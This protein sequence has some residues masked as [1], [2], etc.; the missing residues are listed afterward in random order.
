[1]FQWGY[2]T[3]PDG[4]GVGLPLI[5]RFIDA[6][7]WAVDVTESPEGGARFEIRFDREADRLE[8]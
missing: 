8:A 2:S 3:H 1:V 6:H 7:G 4:D 5:K